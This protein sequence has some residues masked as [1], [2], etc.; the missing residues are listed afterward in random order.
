M[1]IKQNKFILDCLYENVENTNKI[2]NKII[3]P[4][5]TTKIYIKNHITPFKVE[6]V[7]LDPYERELFKSNIIHKIKPLILCYKCDE[8]INLFVAN[9]N[10][11]IKNKNTKQNKNIKQNKNKTKDYIKIVLYLPNFLKYAAIYN[12]TFIPYE[13]YNYIVIKYNFNKKHI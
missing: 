9:S 11:I 13:I 8:R 5:N 1:D 3:L 2:D 12:K 6:Y 7:Y 10:Y 4:F